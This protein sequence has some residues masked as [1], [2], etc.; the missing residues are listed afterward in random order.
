MSGSSIREAIPVDCLDIPAS[1]VLPA[2]PLP[3]PALL[4][5]VLPCLAAWRA[6]SPSS[7]FRCPRERKPTAATIVPES[8]ELKG[9]FARSQ[10]LAVEAK[11]A[12][13]VNERSAD[14]TGSA[15]SFVGSR[16]GGGGLLRP[17]D[18][19]RERPGRSRGLGGR[20]GET[21]SRRRDGDRRGSP[22]RIPRVH[23][24]RPQQKK[25]KKKKKKKAPAATRGP[26]TP[27]GMAKGASSCR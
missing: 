24:P 25:K 6:C 4:R 19:G 26:A 18:R 14:L 7:P 10:V 27:A 11:D 8:V 16:G 21:R 20:D 13:S 12:A 9:N 23:H 3:S 15:L 22:P 1:R 5:G 2:L 17:A